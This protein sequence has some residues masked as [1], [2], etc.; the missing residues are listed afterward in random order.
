MLRN[1]TLSQYGNLLIRYMCEHPSDV[2]RRESK[3]NVKKGERWAD[4]Y[5][6]CFSS[7]HIY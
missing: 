6:D 4:D 3:G 2:F 1:G 5:E 7:Y